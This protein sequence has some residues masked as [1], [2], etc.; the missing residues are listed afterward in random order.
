MEEIQLDNIPEYLKNSPYKSI[1]YKDNTPILTQTYHYKEN[2]KVNTIDDLYLLFH[3]LRHWQ[4]E[5]KHYPYHNI[6]TFIRNNKE[7]DYESFY[8][9]FFDIPFIEQIKILIKSDNLCN[10]SCDNGYLLL[11]KYAHEKGCPWDEMTCSYAALNGCLDCLQYAHEKGCPWDERTCRYAAYY[12]HLKC[13]KYAHE[14]GCYWDRVTC[15]YAA[16]NGHL[17][18]LKYLH[19]NGC[20]WDKDSCWYAALNGHLDCLQYLHENGC[21][22]DEDTC[23]NAAK[24]GHLECLKYA[25]ENGCPR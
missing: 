6:F 2:I 1:N 5:E 10:S 3:T 18:C 19:E 21:P 17:E 24:Y 13:L 20:P 25:R 22:W 8:K 9:T 4:I 16:K 7:L 15:E 11:L 12:G 14:N 23:S